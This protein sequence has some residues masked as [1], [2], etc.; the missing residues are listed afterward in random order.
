MFAFALAVETA[1]FNFN[2]TPEHS[3]AVGLQFIG[4]DFAQAQEIIGG[5]VTVNA[6]QTDRSLRRGSG[7]EMLD[8][9][10]MFV[11]T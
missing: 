4:D 10:T 11:L 3:L 8:Q 7:Y 6:A 1:L 9:T 5:G 2:L